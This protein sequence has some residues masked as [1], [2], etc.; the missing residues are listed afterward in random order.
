MS[1]ARLKC[2]LCRTRDALSS[3]LQLCEVCAYA[4][5]T[6]RAQAE[7]Q[8]ELAEREREREAAARARAKGKAA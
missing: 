7:R 4:Q 6:S 1:K 5:E 3:T 8:V 2:V